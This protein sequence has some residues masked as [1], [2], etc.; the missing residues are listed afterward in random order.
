[1]NA[2]SLQQPFNF[3]VIEQVPEAFRANLVFDS[4]SVEVCG[5]TKKKRALITKI[6]SECERKVRVPVV[7]IKSAIK[8]GIFRGRCRA[9]CMRTNSCQNA[10][11]P[12]TRERHFSW[13]GGRNKTLEGYVQVYEPNHPYAR[14]NGYVAE[15]R[16]VMEKHLGRHLA[17]TESVH[18]KNGIRDDNRIENLELWGESQIKGQRYDDF[19]TPQILDLITFLQGLIKKRTQSN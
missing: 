7:N 1:M 18:H 4:Q 15:H 12:R 10:Q 6:C 11:N 2:G 3:L 9:C 5:K 14:S 8:R 17:P 13:K 16:L 19:S